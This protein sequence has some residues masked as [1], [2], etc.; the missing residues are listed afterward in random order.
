MIRNALIPV[1]TILGPTLAFLVTGS[2][3]IETIFGIPGVGRYYITSISQRDYSLLM[4]MT[5]LYAFAV[6]FLNVVVDVLYALH[7]PA[8]PLQLGGATSMATSTTVAR[9]ASR[10]PQS[11]RRACGAR[12][13]AGCARTSWRWSAWS[14]VIAAVRHRHLRAVHRAVA[15]PR[16][17]TSRRSSRTAAG[18]CRRSVPDHI[19]GTDQLGRDLL[20]RLLDGARISMT[21]AHR[22][23]GR[24]H[25]ASACRSAPSPAGSAAAPTTS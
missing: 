24:R 25:H 13:S 12:P 6:A 18:R 3:I 8:H 2:F 21:V 17:R 15:V 22:R 5:M 14:S 16:S 10:K 20:S 4:A 11:V 1:V 23:P 19:L 9:D 7:R